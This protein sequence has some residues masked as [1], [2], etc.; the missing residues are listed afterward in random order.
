MVHF[1]FL[2]ISDIHFCSGREPSIAAWLDREAL[3]EKLCKHNDIDCLVISGDIFHQGS[4]LP[5]EM[6]DLQAYLKG[7]PGYNNTIIVPGNHDL[8]RMVRKEDKGYNRF[9]YRSDIVTSKSGNFSLN[10]S[11]KDILYNYSFSAHKKA[12]TA[13]NANHRI[14][15][16]YPKPYKGNNV[17]EVSII[18]LPI[19]NTSYKVDLVLLNTSLI[20]GQCIRGQGFKEKKKELRQ[21]VGRLEQ[22]GEYLKCAQKE[23][24]LAFLQEQFEKTGTLDIDEEQIDG[25]GRLGL[26]K[27]GNQALA[28]IPCNDDYTAFTLFVGHHG[29]QFLSSDTCQALKR[30][31]IRRKSELY[32]CGHAHAV[33]YDDSLMLGNIGYPDRMRQCQ[34]G[35]MY[36]DTWNNAQYGYYYG[37]IEIEDDGKKHLKIDAHYC[38]R[39]PAQITVWHIQN[40][41]DTILSTSTFSQDQGNTTT[42]DQLITHSEDA[43]ITEETNKT[44]IFSSTSNKTLPFTDY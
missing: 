33:H 19:R 34:A 2:H 44:N 39:S 21:E 40:V 6:N 30:A 13:L 29:H 15:S 20:A 16:L 3:K 17:Q 1:R 5:N 27:D 4:L 25:C 38:V 7:I 11:E 12:V 9:T 22:N 35:I 36:R 28:A 18:S 10:A 26:T 14:E 24:E 43:E 42:S 37:E 32:L 23:L 41:V 8:D 31:M